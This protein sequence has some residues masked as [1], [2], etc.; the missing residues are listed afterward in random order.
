MQDLQA[1]RHAHRH[2]LGH[3]SMRIIC[4]RN[5]RQNMQANR[6]T[7]H[8]HTQTRE[9]REA[10]GEKDDFRDKLCNHRCCSLN[11]CIA[12]PGG[13]SDPTESSRVQ[14]ALKLRHASRIEFEL[15]LKW[16][17]SLVPIDLVLRRLHWQ[18]HEGNWVKLVAPSTRPRAPFSKHSFPIQ[19]RSSSLDEEPILFVVC[20]AHIQ[21]AK[22]IAFSGTHVPIVNPSRAAARRLYPVSDGQ[23]SRNVHLPAYDALEFSCHLYT[24]RV[25]VFADKAAFGVWLKT[26]FQGVYSAPLQLNAN[27]ISLELRFHPPCFFAPLTQPPKSVK[28]STGPRDTSSPRCVRLTAGTPQM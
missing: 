15:K 2:A 5:V 11:T 25:R 6:A 18:H 3:A 1:T 12:A 19:L 26:I 4:K 7:E 10:R 22:I 28:N 20:L 13:P 21:D 8:V 17:I 24:T 16:L 9:T 23:I 14:P 27:Q